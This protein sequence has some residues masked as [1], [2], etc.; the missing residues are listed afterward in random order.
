MKEVVI[1]RLLKRKDVKD[2]SDEAKEEFRTLVRNLFDIYGVAGFM[3]GRAKKPFQE[4]LAEI[5]K[6]YNIT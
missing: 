2:W 1:N 6:K 4:G 5:K 3:S